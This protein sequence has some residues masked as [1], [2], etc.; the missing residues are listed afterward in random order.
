MNA[1]QFDALLRSLA[2]VTSR[3]GLVTTLSRGLLAALSLHVR[4]EEAAAGRRDGCPEC[5]RCKRRRC[6]P[7]KDRTPCGSTGERQCCDGRCCASGDIC[8][9]GKCVTGQGTCAD[10]ADTCSVAISSCN[11]VPED[12]C[13]CVITTSNET[14]CAANARIGDCGECTDDAF[15]RQ[16]YGPTAFCVDIGH[17]TCGCP[18]IQPAWCMRPCPV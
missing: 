7:E 3:R 6:R 11:G 10:G 17:G 13:T 12:K 5:K 1:L 16:K 15:C 2:S 8:V 18:A 9:R 14:R 4:G